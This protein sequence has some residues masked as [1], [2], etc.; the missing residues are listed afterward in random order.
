[1]TFLSDFDYREMGRVACLWIVQYPTSLSEILYYPFLTLS[2]I[3]YMSALSG[4]DHFLQQQPADAGW[5]AGF[6]NPENRTEFHL[7]TDTVSYQLRGS[8]ALKL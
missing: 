1:M 7:T 5:V 2:N 4:S 3:A 8:K 6:L